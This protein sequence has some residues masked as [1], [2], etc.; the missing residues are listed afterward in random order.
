MMNTATPKKRKNKSVYAPRPGDQR[1]S[2]HILAV[3][4]TNEPGALA[5]VVGLFSGRGYNIDSLTVAETNHAQNISRITIVSSGTPEVIQQITAQLGRLVPVQSVRDLTEHGDIIDR[6]LVL[7]KVIG[8]AVQ[9]QNAGEVADQYQAVVIDDTDTSRV[10]EYSGTTDEIE[11]FLEAL[12]P[13][14]FA[15]ASRTGVAAMSCGTDTL[16]V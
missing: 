16:H 9:M 12:R 14:G 11:S 7:V 13:L 8:D 6:E 15:G 10:F 5:R 1:V 2:S 4:V 3:Y